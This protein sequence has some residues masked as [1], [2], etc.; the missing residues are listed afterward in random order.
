MKPTGE[1]IAG[2]LST[3]LL[4]E[5]GAVANAMPPATAVKSS[6]ERLDAMTDDMVDTSELPPLTEKFFTTARWRTPGQAL[7]VLDEAVDITH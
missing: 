2:E 6:V 3:G 4:Q 5:G 1:L 7:K